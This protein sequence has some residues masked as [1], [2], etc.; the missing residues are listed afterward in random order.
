MSARDREAF[1]PNPTPL[2]QPAS[3]LQSRANAFA[4]TT[5]LEGAEQ[6]LLSAFD[7]R[8]N[9][10][11]RT[12]VAPESMPE[13]TLN[14]AR[15]ESRGLLGAGGMG[16]VR[17]SRDQWIGRDVAHKTLHPDVGMSPGGRA[18]FLREIRVQGQ[19]EHPAIVPVY[20][21]GTSASGELWFTM[22]RIRGQ[23]LAEILD[24]LA[25]GEASFLARFSRRKL[26]TAFTSIALVVHYAHTRGVI[27][28][29][30]KP[31]N[32]MLGDFGE[33][34]VLDW[35]IA[36]VMGSEEVT[37]PVVPDDEPTASGR[38]I[39]TLGYMSPEQARGATPDPRIDVYA[40]GVMLFEILTLESLLQETD[41][42]KALD[43]VLDGVV[44]QP[45]V[46]RADADIPPELDL[47]C[48][49]ATSKLPADRFESAKALSDAVERYLDGDRDLE[50]RR[51]LAKGYLDAAEERGQSAFASASEAHRSRVGALRDVLAAVALAPEEP[52]AIESLAKLVLEPPEGIPDE[53]HTERQEIDD[54]ARTQGAL[55]GYRA[56]LSFALSFPIMVI[57]GVR[58][59]PLVAGGML[60]V[61][62]TAFIFRWVHHTRV[63]RTPQFALL[64]L[65]CLITVLIQ[66]TWLGPFVLMPIAATIVTAI[67]ALYAT[68]RERPWAIVAGAVT[69]LIP[70]ALEWVPGLP[71]GFTFEG[72]RVVLHPRALEL[73]MAATTIGLL[74]TTVG[75][76]I[77]PA[78]FLSR[79]KNALRQSEDRQFLQAWTLKQLFPRK[80]P[81]G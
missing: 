31:S 2:Y 37:E 23:T 70:F 25:R 28:R 81:A 74:Y 62:L 44:A 29:D 53:A 33:V 45:R 67:F 43:Q 18:R 48:E 1:D 64:L 78:I 30:L 80:T 76:A 27:H 51:E 14:T 22:R 75:Y 73:P 46:R 35:G 7:A 41:Q 56:F 55:L 32:V 11:A 66:S 79:L 5:P 68:P 71:R 57:A 59:W 36:K 26:L 4:P 63:P 69:V 6:T 3:Q 34:Y 10:E 72:G 38:V 19:L 47:I 50:R 21:V 8:K 16:E 60:I 49:R 65:L 58:S 15:Y 52:R 9:S 20:D 61:L 24:G 42:L 77:L 54:L 40:L 12:I 17:L 13:P 39:G